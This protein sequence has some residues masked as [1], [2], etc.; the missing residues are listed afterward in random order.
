MRAS[1]AQ[2]FFF[3]LTVA[4]DHARDLNGVSAKSEGAGE[5]AFIDGR[6][7]VDR[8]QVSEKTRRNGA[9]LKI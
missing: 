6:A 9:R 5:S 1:F 8:R 3:A 2:A 4:G 7:P